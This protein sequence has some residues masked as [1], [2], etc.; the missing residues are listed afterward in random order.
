M[1]RILSIVLVLLVMGV[2]D[3]SAQ[4]FLEKVKKQAEKAIIEHVEKAVGQKKSGKSKDQQKPAANVQQQKK[5]A[6]TKYVAIPDGHTALFEPAGY[7]SPR[8]RLG[9]KA[10]LPITDQSQVSKWVDSQVGVEFSTNERLVDEYIEYEKALE[11]WNNQWE[12]NL[13]RRDLVHREILARSAEIDNF[14]GKL[15]FTKNPD[16]IANYERGDVALSLGRIIEGEMYKRTLNSSIAPLKPYMHKETVE[17]L[18]SYGD[19]A[20]LHSE[21]KTSWY[22][23]GEVEEVQTSTEGL[24]GFVNLSGNIDVHGLMF[25]IKGKEA[26]LSDIDVM[27]LADEE[28]DIPGHIIRKGV[29]YPVTRIGESSFAEGTAKVIHIP[30]TVKVLERNAFLNMP[31]LTAVEIPESVTELGLGCFENCPELLEIRL[32][33]SVKKIDMFCFRDCK[34]LKTAV[35]P[36]AIDVLEKNVFEGC[37]SLASVNLPENLTTIPY[38]IFMGCKSLAEIKIPAGVTII[39][40][41]AF[42]GCSK[43]KEFIFPDGLKRIGASV[44]ENCTGI[45]SLTIPNSVEEIGMF[46]MGC[47][48]LKSVTLN[49]SY[50]NFYKLVGSFGGT[51]LFPESYYNTA[52]IPAAFKFVD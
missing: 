2:Q 24:E 22:P 18:E 43:L 20:T 33:E 8:G 35:L 11:D 3:M 10:V 17:Y 28:V 19:L 1:R 34:K 46:T 31:N 29:S 5:P 26:K 6:Q 21:E 41:Y 45:T 14:V 4:N 7:P 38:K 49:S 13:V 39:D 12:G 36:S 48:A 9:G 16:D 44:L 52:S 30:N 47:K 51:E 32:P 23:Y 40:D 25:T 42:S 37:S 27:N 50:N 15:K